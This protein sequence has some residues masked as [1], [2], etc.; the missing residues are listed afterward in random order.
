MSTL[1]GREPETAPSAARQSHPARE[2][3]ERWM[4][5][6]LPRSEAAGVVRHL[7][8]GCPACFQVTRRLWSLGD[9][10]PLD[11]SEGEGKG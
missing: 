2:Q 3:L 7:L 11:D 5:G 6:E 10:V 9:R 4:R 1:L 8:T